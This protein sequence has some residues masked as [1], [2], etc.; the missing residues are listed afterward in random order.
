MDS[1]VGFG[2]GFGIRK[3][4]ND[5]LTNATATRRIFIRACGSCRSR[6]SVLVGVSSNG[7]TA[8]SGAV[9]EG[10]TPSTP[11]N[12]P[13]DTAGKSGILAKRV[14]WLRR[15]A[16]RTPPFQGG[17]RRFEP[18]RSYQ[19]YSQAIGRF[20]WPVLRHRRLLLAKKR[21]SGGAH[22]RKHLGDNQIE[23]NVPETIRHVHPRLPQH[24]RTR[25]P[26]QVT[27]RERFEIA[28]TCCLPRVFFAG[29]FQ[30]FR[31]AVCLSLQRV[32]LR[33][34]LSWLP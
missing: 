27:R 2:F 32:G 24:A 11:A 19:V 22:A 25:L 21:R 1:G 30:S 5:L 12:F 4:R 29:V 17:G 8:V 15:L 3:T 18:G 10:S 16:V 34:A 26:S 33:N 7:R 14:K 6:Q 13:L 20:R 23:R 31:Y 28:D 9:C